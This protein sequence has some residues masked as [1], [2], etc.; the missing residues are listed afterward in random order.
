MEVFWYE[1]GVNPPLTPPRRGS[2][3]GRVRRNGR[4]RGGSRIFYPLI[5]LQLFC[6]LF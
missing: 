4:F 5:F 3:E 1:V 6:L 2:Q